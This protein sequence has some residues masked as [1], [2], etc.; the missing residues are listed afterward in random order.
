[1]YDQILKL[2]VDEPGASI[3]R[4]CRVFHLTEYR[5]KR[6][7]RH[8]EADLRGKTI[9]HDPNHGVWI[10]EVDSERCL[11]INWAGNHTADTF[12]AKENRNFLTDAVGVIPAGKI[13]K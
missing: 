8:I 4:L 10:V 5:L 7:L 11:G 3:E 1:M 6:I 13:P 2:I 12:S 9:V